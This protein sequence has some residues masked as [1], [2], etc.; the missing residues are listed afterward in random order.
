[1][2]ASSKRWSAVCWAAAFPEQLLVLFDDTE[3]SQPAR[4]AAF[5]DAARAALIERIAA[6]GCRSPTEALRNPYRG[7]RA[8]TE[9]DAPDFFGRSAIVRQ[10][11]D[12]FADAGPDARFLAVVG[13]SGCGK[14]SLVRAG[15]V[16]AL[17]DGA[18]G[19][20]GARD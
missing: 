13:P 9:A 17:R 16:P 14:S 18:F 6:G 8:F 4:A 1:M 10:V 5:A 19:R 2:S 3:Q 7:L 15:V 20:A 12:R 11:V